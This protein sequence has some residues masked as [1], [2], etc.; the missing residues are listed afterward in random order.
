M[1]SQHSYAEDLA[2]KAQQLN[3]WYI[4]VAIL[5][6]FENA[7]MAKTYNSFVWFVLLMVSTALILLIFDLDE[8]L[9]DED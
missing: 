4:Q 2:K 8:V 3:F 5:A 6:M 9:D 7:G 1:P